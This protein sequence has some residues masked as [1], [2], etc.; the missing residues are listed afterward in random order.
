MILCR[1]FFSDSNE[2]KRYTWQQQVKRLNYWASVDLGGGVHTTHP[3]T[4]FPMNNDVIHIAN[5]ADKTFCFKNLP[6]MD[7]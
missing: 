2:S 6:V 1:F 7:Y 5:Y 3:P 4:P